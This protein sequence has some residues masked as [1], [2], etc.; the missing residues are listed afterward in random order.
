MALL[1]SDTHVLSEKQEFSRFQKFYISQ[2][3]LALNQFCHRIS[4]F[5]RV[6]SLLSA[7]INSGLNFFKQEKDLHNSK[8]IHKLLLL[9]LNTHTHTHM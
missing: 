7:Y 8:L 1:C 2:D 6:Y 5:I 3:L 9:L 4:L